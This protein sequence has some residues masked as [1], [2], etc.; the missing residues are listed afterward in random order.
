MVHG[1]SLACIGVSDCPISGEGH[2]VVVIHEHVV[3]HLGALVALAK[4]LLADDRRLMLLLL[5]LETL[6]DDE[7]VQV[8]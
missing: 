6:P 7:T 2:Q 4:L 5:A 8:G 3:K 1:A